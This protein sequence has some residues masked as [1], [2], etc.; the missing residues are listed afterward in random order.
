[1][2]YWCAI[3]CGVGFVICYFFLEETNYTRTVSL[4]STPPSPVDPEMSSSN[5]DTGKKQQD[6][7]R[8]SESIVDDSIRVSGTKKSFWAKLVHFQKGTFSKPNH[9][10]DMAKRP[11]IFIS[12]PVIFCSG[13]NYG[14]NLVWF[15]VLNGTSS[16]IIF[17]PPYTF[18]ATDI[19]L[20]YLAPLI[21]RSTTH[22]SLSASD[23][24]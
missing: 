2:L 18:S 17:N 3:F 16:L 8:K 21:G 24:L 12:F 1:M 9:M 5:A 6:T 23:L 10:L 7:K 22:L 13:F 11:L 20:A 14:S 19:G 15:N 4:E